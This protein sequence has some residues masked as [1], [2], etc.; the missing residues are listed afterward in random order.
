MSGGFPWLLVDQNIDDGDAVVAACAD[1]DGL[2]A[3][4]GEP[5]VER[6]TLLGCA[7][8]G[9][10]RAACDGYGSAWLGNIG[11]ETIHRPDSKHPRECWE[12]TE[13]LLDL[14][15]LSARPA[16]YGVYDVVLEGRLRIDPEHRKRRRGPD[17]A[18][19][20]DGYVLTGI[21]GEGEE[22]FGTCQDVSGVFRP[23]PQPLPKP[24]TL[25]GCRPEPRLRRAI[26]A[27]QRGAA[28]HRRMI[29]ASIYS[30]ADDGTATHML[31]S[32]LGAEVADVR[33]SVLGDALVDV[34]FE[35]SYGDAIKGGRPTGAREI[36]ELWRRG[37]PEKPGLWADFPA[38][39]RHEWAGAALAHH[40][41]GPDRRS[42]RTYHLDGRYITDED[43]FYCAIGEAIN[44]PGGYFGWN[45]GALHDCLLGDWG[46]APGFRLIW[47]DSEVARRHLV[48]GYDRRDW[49]PAVTMDHLLAWLAED[50]VEVELR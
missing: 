14:T 30:V 38:A 36:W 49:C 44:G 20:A 32:G 50:G 11:L 9:R 47:H 10:L 17:R 45:T 7:P 26:E 43:G 15:V 23:R 21:T 19:E 3:D 34:T 8:A 16:G 1:I 42:G 33:P 48:P 5:P 2:F 6:Y 46:A 22:M 28:R 25:I 41:P 24:A 27:Q 12:C 40:R 13:E 29:I 37:R 18:P 39:L 4:P 31:D 35:S